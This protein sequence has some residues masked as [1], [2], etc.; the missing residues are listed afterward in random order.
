MTLICEKCGCENHLDSES[1]VE[2]GHAIDKK[3]AYVVCTTC[4]LSNP[5]SAK[6]CV[7]CGEPL[8]STSTFVVDD[9]DKED[10]EQVLSQES[11]GV[12]K[13]EK[14]KKSKKK[15]EFKKYLGLGIIA[16]SVISLII[17][18]VMIIGGMKIFLEA[19]KG[20]YYVTDTGILHVVDESGKD[21]VV[22]YDVSE[23]TIKKYGS[24]LY[25]LNNQDLYLHHK[26]TSELVG[27]DVTSF[28]VNHKGD[29]VLYRS[30]QGD[31]YKYDGKENLRIDGNVGDMRYIFGQK[32]DVYYVSEITDDED[33]GVLYMKRG[34]DAPVSITGDVYEPLFSMKRDAVYYV[35]KPVNE[36]ERFDV[37]FIRKGSVTEISRNITHIHYHP[38]KENFFM[39]QY[40]NSV[41][42]LLSVYRNEVEIIKE[43][44]LKSGIKRFGDMKPVNIRED[45]SMILHEEET[46]FYFDGKDLSELKAF[47]E[48]LLADSKILTIE[49]SELNHSDFNGKIEND[50]SIARNAMVYDMS[51][52][53]QVYIYETGSKY[54]VANQKS[55]VLNDAVTNAWVT[56]NEA[57]IMYLEGR[58][59]Y[60]LKIGAE[61]PVFLGSNVQDIYSIDNYIYTLVDDGLYRYKLGK[62]SSNTMISKVRTWGLLK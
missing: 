59:A 56:N 29:Q 48:F 24:R 30:S 18:I 6:V 10:S 21:L 50:V 40:K 60:V 39:I 33:L 1:C 12:V 22:G 61:E 55:T 23:P 43:G 52:T 8:N 3:E 31:L 36:V 27:S 54:L 7:G 19:D 28:K 47:D 26:G 14:V 11:T 38:N 51:E 44:F 42:N 5:Q 57:Y 53:G 9:S 46:N 16:A 45:F 34:T 2:C 35:R 17:V 41:E 32:T 37:Y 62:F 49:D 15:F 4:G 25:Y 13:K 20:F 58:D